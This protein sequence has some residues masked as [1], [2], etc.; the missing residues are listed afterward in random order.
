MG[1]LDKECF[2]QGIQTWDEAGIS[3][4]WSGWTGPPTMK[5]RRANSSAK[6]GVGGFSESSERPELDSLGEYSGYCMAGRMQR[7]TLQKLSG[8]FQIFSPSYVTPK[9]SSD[10]LQ[11]LL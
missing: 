5:G 7:Q 11:A 6:G 8:L 9:I 3:G 4:G 1:G 10:T 2:I